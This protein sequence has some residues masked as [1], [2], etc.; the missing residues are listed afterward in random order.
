[1]AQAA[2]AGG[3]GGGEEEEGAASFWRAVPQQP[4]RQGKGS[5][6]AGG[7]FE[8]RFSGDASPD[9]AGV[10]FPGQEPVR[11]LCPHPH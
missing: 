1:M 4:P 8:A 10:F 7:W 11:P 6:G 2:L 3:W 9:T 5:E